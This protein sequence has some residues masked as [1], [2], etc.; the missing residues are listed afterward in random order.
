[1]SVMDVMRRL[2]YSIAP[3]TP[4]DI[5]EE[6]RFTLD[7]Y[8]EDLVRKGFSEENAR[9]KARIDLGR[10]ASQNETYRRAIGHRLFDE[11]GGDICYGLRQM[12][13]NPAFAW[14]AVITLG[15]GIGATTA[16]FSA[17][18]ALLIRPLP[19][20]DSN[21]LMEI[22]EA[23]PK[24]G[25]YGGPLISPDFVAAQLSLRSFESVAGFDDRGDMNLTGTGDPIRV[26]VVG[27]TAN[28][29]PQLHVTPERG[30]SF[31]NSEDRMGGPAVLLLS[32]RLWEGK[33]NGDGR[34]IGQSIT[35]G[36]KAWIVAGVLPARFLFPDPAIEPDLYIPA[37]LD[38][39]TSV[40]PSTQVYPMHAIGRLRDGGSLPQAIAELRLFVDARNKG[41][42]P[43]LASWAKERV[44]LAEPLHNYLTGDDR[45]PLLILLACV[46]AVLLIACANVANLQLARS[47]ARQREMALRGALG[48]GRLRL[49]R[50]FLVESLTLA[51][52]AA[53][54]G[55]GIAVLVTWLIRRG[56][57]PGEFSSGSRVAELLQVPFGKLSV[58]IQVDGW[59]LAF[60]A[61]LALFTTILFGL[62][63]AIGASRSDLRTALQS[64][65]RSI[66][67]SRQ[68]RQLRSALLM[69]EIG[70]AVLLLTG[71]GLLIR[72]FVNVLRSDSGYDP[73]QCLTP[74][75]RR[76]YPDPPE[77]LR[78]FVGQ[79]LPRLRALPGVEA[80]AFASAFPLQN[81]G[82]NTAILPADG[83]VPP[84][85]DI[86]VSN[87]ISISPE[88]F[89]AAGTP[90]LRGRAFNDGDQ[91]DS[92]LV[93]VVNQAFV[94]Q[95]IKGDALDKQVRT[96]INTKGIGQYNRRTIVGVVQDVRYNG[97]E[98]KIEPVI[99]LP[100]AQVP[101][102]NLDILL[103]ASV[104]P[105]SLST[106]LRKAVTD[107]DPA[108]PLS[109]IQTMEGRISQLVAQRRL[110]MLLIA[111]FAFL[112]LML[113]GVGVYGVFTYWVSQRS[114]EMGIRLALGASRR[115]LLRLIMLQAIRL[116]LIGGFAGIVGAWFLDHSL[117][118]T[119][120]GVKVHDPASLALAWALMTFIALLGSSIPALHA[121]RT[122]I[123]SV[124]HSE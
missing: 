25:T 122:D 29:L 24:S 56:G 10:P 80:A 65:S 93:A 113:A 96:N 71:A 54:L 94:R 109:D 44:I 121:S 110:I 91:A 66:S 102:L 41:Y 13:H 12:R 101:Q 88:Y 35:L 120:V 77:K 100:I 87:A 106:S 38:A 115:G 64:A 57:M 84:P 95:F 6:F 7:A 19:Y 40:G 117:A 30:R 105:D 108:Q 1:M 70:L 37:G 61:G 107:T 59:V 32:H 14:T 97:A 76:N 36:G 46:G 18:Y 99:Y 63:P 15:L 73:R 79:L 124:L 26:R 60:T 116:V 43:V 23:F 74:Q 42:P 81:I 72:S 11:F 17:V 9:R 33:F 5:D 8:Q 90:V 92:A 78:N 2:W 119:L 34:V 27:I 75:L 82:P 39:D 49:I 83:P 104:E 86:Q 50:Q 21:R 85:A 31:L 118:T 53:I 16:I 68:Q 3:R 45:K 55:L 111:A 67:S 20:P 114:Q 58:A 28:F 62:A 4:S 89:R 69:A 123:I 103:R 98:G 52:L 112:A 48:A 22:S 51:T 47:V